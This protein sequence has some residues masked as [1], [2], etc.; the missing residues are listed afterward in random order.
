LG[1]EEDCRNELVQRLA[2]IYHQT[3]QQCESLIHEYPKE[4][5]IQNRD[6]LLA[7]LAMHRLSL[8][9]IQEKLTIC[10]LANLDNCHS[11]MLYS[12][13]EILNN[14]QF[15]I[16]LPGKLKVP[17]PSEAKHLLKIQSEKLFGNLPNSNKPLMM[18][19]L[20]AIMINQQ[21]LIEELLLNG[22][23]IARINCAHNHQ[24]I[25]RQL[26]TLLKTTEEKLR[27][28][29]L[30]HDSSCKIFMDLAGPKVRIGKV[31]T[32]DLFVKKGDLLRLYLN[33][34]QSSHL[35]T[36]EIPAGVPVTQEKA[37][38]NVSYHDKIFIDDGKIF[39]R[40]CNIT[41]DYVEL[42]IVYPELRPL[43]IKSGKG[44][45]LPDSLLSLNLPALTNKDI[46]DL[47]FVT[48]YADI[49]GVSFVHSPLDLKK[50]REQLEKHGAEEMA[51]V[52]KIE[53]K[54]AIHQTGRIILEG[55]RF[56]SFGIM[57]ARGDLAVEVGP[58]KLAMVQEELL[59]ICSAA[60][61]PVIWATGVLERMTK[62]GVPSRAEI[63]DAMQG[64]RAD[65][66]MLNKGPFVLESLRLLRN[67]ASMGETLSF[68]HK[69]APRSLTA[70]FGVFPY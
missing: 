26:I 42:E 66:I 11:H 34:Q 24:E 70:Q 15:P 37:F 8:A 28:E 55:L 35:A 31:Q 41:K 52:A 7:Y 50:L 33:S 38:Q 46:D 69:C 22:M 68:S 2:L 10:G 43:R 61:I 3:V 56:A 17:T 58:D 5:C 67:I 19:T 12:I 44:I 14:L 64:L 49:L 4:S 63:T 48:K 40:V 16:N 36:A 13:R 27:S 29:G 18:V 47:A 62:K 1:S 53:T 6:N 23:S 57:I 30:Y 32:M 39:G 54:D 65:C 51:V 25:W 9:D 20:D 45:N 60:Y 59:A 21:S